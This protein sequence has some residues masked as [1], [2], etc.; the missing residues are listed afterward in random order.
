V[1]TLTIKHNFAEVQRALD[2][3]QRDIADRARYSALNKTMQQA[4]TAMSREIRSEYNL[5]LGEVNDRLRIDLP[6]FARGSLSIEARLTG[7]GKS[8]RGRSMNV[9][10]FVER[11]ISLAQAKKRR[12]A[13]EGAGGRAFALR[14]KIKKGGPSKVIK[15]AFI[16]NR[17]RTVFER[18]GKERLPIRAVQTID[19]PQMFNARKT[20]GAV[21]AL[22]KR[23][24]PVIA[25][26]EIAYYTR[27]FNNGKT[28]L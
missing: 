12:K 9:I 15:G 7:R 25:Q 4:R 17:G 8:G 10:R 28:G 20:K 16:G 11:V 6:R 23:Q 27:I 18:E 26:R 19:V 13:G 22:I 24:F 1:V 5:T 21:L 3:L 2:G 14:V